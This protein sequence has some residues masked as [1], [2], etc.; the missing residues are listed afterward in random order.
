MIINIIDPLNLSQ[1]FLLNFDQENIIKCPCKVIKNTNNKNK[2]L[3]IERY[4]IKFNV[5]NRD[6]SIYISSIERGNSVY[7]IIEII[8]KDIM[9][10]NKFIKIGHIENISRYEKYSGSDLM[11]LNLKILYRL[12]VDESTLKDVYYYECIR[13]NFFKQK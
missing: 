9:K 3:L 2:S 5:F 12:K 10:N 6:N 8:I 13:K 4:N 11:L 7:I 1:D